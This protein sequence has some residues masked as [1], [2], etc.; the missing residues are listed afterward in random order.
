MKDQ[1]HR[2][3][4]LR[5]Q[6]KRSSNPLISYN[7]YNTYYFYY[8]WYNLSF[9]ASCMYIASLMMFARCLDVFA[10][11]CMYIAS[12]MM[13]ARCLD[14][15]AALCMYIASLMMFARCLDLRKPV[16]GPVCKA[17]GILHRKKRTQGGRE[18]LQCG[19]A[20]LCV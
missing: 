16:N 6:K 19:G 7:I 10:A 12:L 18:V 8:S 4:F 20:R 13:F 1:R 2:D 14:V 11:S 5:I 3:Y 17:A 15:F 9:A